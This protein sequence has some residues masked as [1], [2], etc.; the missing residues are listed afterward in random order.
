MAGKPNARGSA[1][2][3]GES[4]VGVIQSDSGGTAGRRESFELCSRLFLG[5]GF[6]GVG[7]WR[8]FGTVFNRG[9]SGRGM[10]F[11]LLRESELTAD[12]GLDG[13]FLERYWGISAEKEE[14]RLAKGKGNE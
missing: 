5:A 6:W 11:L 10:E 9:V 13:I 14:I 3:R 1:V 7:E 12:F 2:C 8:N 4:G